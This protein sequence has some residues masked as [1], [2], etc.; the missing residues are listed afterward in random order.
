MR[1]RRVFLQF[2]HNFLIRDQIV[3]QFL[4]FWEKEA[5]I[6]MIEYGFYIDNRIV[7]SKGLI[8]KYIDLEGLL[9]Y[10]KMKVIS[11]LL[12]SILLFALI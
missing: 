12:E 2:F 3:V 10:S 4:R 6:F 1:R 5:E 7:F 9:I 11:S 8:T